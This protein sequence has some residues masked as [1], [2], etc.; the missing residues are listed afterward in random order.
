MRAREA[1]LGT[2]LF[3]GDI[4]R[5]MPVCPPET[6]DSASFDE[7]LE[8][9]CLGGRS[10]PHAVMMMMPEAWENHA[11]MPADQREFYQ[12]HASLME[13]WDG[14]A[15]VVFTDGTLMGATLDRNGLR[16]ARWWQLADDRVV[17][18]SES[19]VLEVDPS[20][21]VAK[22][23]LRPGRMFLVDTAPARSSTTTPT[24]R[25]WPPSEPYGEWL[26]AGLCASTTSRPRARG[27]HPRLGAAPP[28]DLRL[29]RGGPAHPARADGDHRRRA[30]GFDGHRHPHRGALRGARGCSTTTSSSC[31]RRSPTRRWT[32]SARSSSPAWGGPIGPEQNLFHPGPASCRQVVLPTPGHRQRRAREAD[33]H[34]RRRR[35]ARLRRHRALGALRGRGRRGRAAR[36]PRADP[37]RGSHAIAEG[38][39]ILVLSDRDSD[40]RY[41]PIPA[42]LLTSAVHHHL[43]GTRERTQVGAGRRVG[44]RPRGAPH[45]AAA[46]LRGRRDQPLPRV[47]VD[48]GPVTSG[49]LPDLECDQAIRNYVKALVKGVLKVMS[50]MGISTVS[51]Y[52]AAQ[53]FEA[54]GLSQDFLAEYFTGTASKLGGGG[55][56]V[57]AAE[58]AA[59]HR[60]AYPSNPDRAGPP[61]PRRRRRVRLPARGRAAPVHPR[62]GVP[63]AALHAHQAARRVPA[64][65]RRVRPDRA[66]GRPAARPVP[67]ALRG[68]HPD[69][70][71]EVESAD[72]DRQA[73]RHRAR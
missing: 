2:D 26:H 12:F 13:P 9:L 43:V 18:A 11:E 59:R 49:E 35:H 1:L 72:R 19:G 58:V 37:P 45:G 23:R 22:G 25:S 71:D 51:G 48:R 60:P 36:R 28:A 62:D 55:L 64:V 68:P 10:L 4:Q 24:S 69:A 38:K 30:A 56:D 52:T 3:P 50:K 20:Q 57:V 65:H 67:A 5:A 32:P 21:V 6:S 42:L 46:L 44:R 40:A 8:L 47:R 27:A 15:A 16:P 66:A 70:I 39:R 14:P 54:V 34:Q 33:P 41:A 53:V 7:V 73:L 63:A 29:H 61:H 17:L 31:S